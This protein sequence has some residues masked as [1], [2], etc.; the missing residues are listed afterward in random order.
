[1][2]QAAP[3][4]A[5]TAGCIVLIFSGA[6]AGK[7]AVWGAL[8]LGAIVVADLLRANQPWIAGRMKQAAPQ[9]LVVP[10]AVPDDPFLRACFLQCIR[11]NR[12]AVRVQRVRHG[13]G[14]GAAERVRHGDRRHHLQRDGVAGLQLQ[15]LVIHA[16]HGPQAAAIEASKTEEFADEYAVMVEADKPLERDDVLADV[17]IDGY[18]TSWAKGLGLLD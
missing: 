2:L 14:V 13:M 6:F 8:L 15:G 17:E 4:L 18:A 10:P 3:F 9:A 1:M 5:L 11:Q 12:Q 7:R 16:Q